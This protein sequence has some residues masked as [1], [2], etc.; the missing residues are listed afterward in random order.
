MP[1]TIEAMKDP[2]YVEMILRTNPDVIYASPFVRT[3][4]TAEI[5]QEIFRTHRKKD[6][7][8]VLE[9]GFAK[10]SGKEVRSYTTLVEKEVGKNV[11]I[12]SHAP[13]FDVLR[14]HF[15]DKD[16]QAT[17]NK[18][19]CIKMPTTVINNE[20]DRWILAALHEVGLE[21]EKQMNEYSLD[22]GAKTVLSFVDK[23]N[24]WF[25]RRSRRRFWANGMDS[26]K[27]SAYM[28]L[29]EV[30]DT[31]MKFCAPFA[32]FLAEHIYL[33]L[34][35]FK[36]TKLIEGD[37][38]HLQ[39]LPLSSEQYINHA[40]LDEISLVRRIISLGLFIRSK[41]KIAVKQPLSKME[42]KM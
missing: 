31:Y 27:A 11:L 36:T 14:P 25:I 9:D 35:E 21:L 8:I 6:I 30:L 42:I 34:Q 19:E 41:N 15:Y 24:N 10:D 5:I 17:I 20:L 12:V 28:T 38:V 26:H 37:S 22:G 32:P 39:Y 16:S 3:K 40:L 18:M 7:P 29:F 4:K 23:L 1:E 13:T 33:A 2:A